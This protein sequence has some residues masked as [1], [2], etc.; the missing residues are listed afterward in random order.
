MQGER[1]EP[2]RAAMFTRRALLLGAGATALLGGLATRMYQLQILD[3]DKYETLAED[4][5][6]NLQLLT[7]PRGKILDRF[8]IELAGNRPNYRVLIIPD[9][10]EG[11]DKALDLVARFVDITPRQ[12]EQVLRDA[13]TKHGL[14]AVT[15]AENLNWNVFAEINLA[16]PEM[17]G[18]VAD[19]GQVRTYPFGSELSHVLGYVAAVS[20]SDLK[21]RDDGDPLLRTPDFPIGKNGVERAVDRDLRGKGGVRQIEV[22]AHGR[23]I[24]ELARQEGTPGANIE[25]TLDMDIQRFAQERLKGESASVVLM[26]VRSG[27]ILTFVSSPGFDP[28][29]FITGFSQTRWEEMNADPLKPLLN[30][31]LAGEYAPGSTFK[32]VTALA[33]L[34]AGAIDAGTHIRCPGY[35]RLGKFT[36]HCHRRGGHGSVDVVGALKASC[37]VFFYEVGRRIGVDA[38]AA[39]ANRLG[40][41]E[42][43]GFDVPGERRGTVPSTAWKMERFGEDLLPGDALNTAI[44]QGYVTATPLQLATMV[45]RIA[46]G[47]A[48]ITPHIVRRV[49][50]GGVASPPAEPLEVSPASIALVHAGMD[51]VVNAAGGTAGRSRLKGP[52][53]RMAGKT[54]TAQVRGAKA[55]GGT[56]RG[57]AVPWHLRNHALFVAFAPVEAPRYGIA[58]VV[59]H[60]QGGSKAAAPVAKDI[61]ERVL[62][63]DPVSRPTGVPFVSAELSPA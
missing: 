22:N 7:P 9:Q 49:G 15:V 32:L 28:N 6:I 37:N 17:P 43:F 55:A 63:R 5:R 44:G 62:E 56:L 40:L 57:N 18:V 45:S 25:L 60:G 1:D 50:T 41:G 39:M 34:E 35:M 4:N 59:E 58:V 19:V 38:I 3:A 53:M 36:F 8:G 47:G 2:E 20:E 10:T 51:A 54:G 52:G 29:E 48:A 21:N 14:S 33:G 30:K 24:R 42:K 31:A 26:D 12:R 11:V 61:M 27:E 16:L 46:N 23:V 13:K